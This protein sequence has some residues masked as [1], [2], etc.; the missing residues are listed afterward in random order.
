MASWNSSNVLPA[1]SA[2][3]R[4]AR[5]RRYQIPWEMNMVPSIAAL[6]ELVG[7]RVEWAKY[8]YTRA[9][10][11][12]KVMSNVFWATALVRPPSHYLQSS[13]HPVT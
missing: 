5:V 10:K 6:I 4:S 11:T 12:P 8:T 13:T 2:R 3:L 1:S 7:R 9:Y